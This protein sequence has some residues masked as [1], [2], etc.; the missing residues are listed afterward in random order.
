MKQSFSFLFACCLL[1]PSASALHAM[2]SEIETPQHGDQVAGVQDSLPSFCESQVHRLSFPYSWQNQ[3]KGNSAFSMTHP[4]L[5]ND[6]DYPDLA[7]LA[8][9]KPMLLFAGE[10]DTLFPIPCVK[11]AFDKMHQVWDGQI[12]GDKL[13]TRILPVPHLFNAAMQDEAFVWLDRHFQSSPGTAEARLPETKATVT[14]DTGAPAKT[15]NPMI[16]GGFLEHFDNQI[17][18]GVFE[19]GSPL[20]DEKGFRLDVIEALMELKVPVVRWPGGCF[21]D[22]YH[23]QNGVGKNRKSSGDPRWGVIEPNTFGTDEFVEF[24]RRIDAEPYICFNGL[25]DPQENLDW[26]SYCNATEGRFAAL[27]KANGHLE[28]FHVKFWSV[29][30]ERYDK[31]YIHRVRDTARAMEAIDPNVL[32]TCSGS[33]GGM[34]PTGSPVHSYLLETAGEHLDYISVHNYWLARANTLPEY[35]YLTAITKSEW[36]NAYIRLVID[37]LVE[38]DRGSHLKIAFDEWNLRAWQHPGFPRASVENYQAPDVR[39]LVE[40]RRKQND[41][42]R[43]YT[44]ADAMFA[45][46]FFNACLRHSDYVTMANVAPLVNT[47]GPLFVH[48]KGIVR[49]THFHTMAMY[50]NELQE[51]VAE[52]RVKAGSLLHGS[53]SVDVVDAIAT[54]NKSGNSWAIALMNRHPSKNVACTVNM[55]DTPLDG[56]HTATVLTGESPDA[57][58]DIEHPNRVAPKKVQVMFNNG[59]VDLPP[60]SLTI[61]FVP[62]ASR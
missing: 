24:C 9:P 48:P 40:L 33:Q 19:P 37:S 34:R 4:G 16:F 54:V 56:A 42:A 49:R 45:A 47:R 25:A 8:C 20:A 61:V 26:V 11:E 28:P 30:N 43:Q 1:V 60:H 59:V 53:E 22:A 5:F 51:Q 6:L 44:M 31:A 7:S 17:Y 46:S 29:G 12:A 50:A 27:R 18:G 52:L 58:N 32:V 23:W 41:V 14:I 21:V 36:P 57:F 15:Y 13:V 62:Y 55:S 35:D 2:T 10:Q 3:T 38:S 39:K